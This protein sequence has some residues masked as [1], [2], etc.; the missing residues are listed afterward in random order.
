MDGTLAAEGRDLIARNAMLSADHSCA[1]EIQHELEKKITLLEQ[2][3]QN[4]DTS[5]RCGISLLHVIC[6]LMQNN[7][8]QE[9]RV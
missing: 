8:W 5:S 9:S 2:T 7:I 3:L 1:Q 6:I 4:Q